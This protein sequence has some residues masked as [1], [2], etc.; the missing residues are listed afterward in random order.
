MGRYRKTSLGEYSVS[1]STSSSIKN[2]N[3]QRIKKRFHSF[4]DIRFEKQKSFYLVLHFSFFLD[5]DSTGCTLNSI[6]LKSLKRNRHF[7]NLLWSLRISILCEFSHLLSFVLNCLLLSNSY[8][9][10]SNQSTS[11][12]R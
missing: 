9:L 1:S 7:D 11:A 4:N 10:L 5:F 6:C 3:K 8:S 12:T 2:L